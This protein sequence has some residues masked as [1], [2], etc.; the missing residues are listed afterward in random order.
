MSSAITRKQL[1]GL[2]TF[3]GKNKPKKKPTIRQSTQ[4]RSLIGKDNNFSSS[5]KLKE[6]YEKDVDWNRSNNLKIL[7]KTDQVLSAREGNIQVVEKVL[8]D[9]H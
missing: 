3:Y 6:E 9:I 1:A 2:N 8:T 5:E 4:D 7:Q